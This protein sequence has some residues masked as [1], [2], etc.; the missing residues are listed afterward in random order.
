MRLYFQYFTMPSYHRILICSYVT[1]ACEAWTPFSRS[2]MEK[3]GILNRRAFVQATAT[4]VLSIAPPLVARSDDIGKAVISDVID[5]AETSATE[6]R[7]TV[8]KTIYEVASDDENE[9]IEAA[10]ET[11]DAIQKGEEEILYEIKKEEADEMNAGEDERELIAEI[12][13]QINANKDEISSKTTRELIEKLEEEEETIEEETLDLIQRVETLEA[14]SQE[15]QRPLFPEPGTAED[16]I[17]KSKMETEEFVSKLK[18]RATEKEDLITKLKAQSAKDI[19]PKTG[20]YKIMTKVEFESRAPSDFD[21]L[22]YLQEDLAKDEV[23][24]RDLDF[25]RERLESGRGLLEN[26]RESLLDKRRQVLEISKGKVDSGMEKMIPVFESSKEKLV[27][28][29]DKLAP[30]FETTKEMV[31]AG[32]ESFQSPR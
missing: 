26:S 29:K 4:L 19:D 7:N 22:K 8:D 25:F 15:A 9:T 13:E 21:F 18:E 32:L 20:K 11:I 30:V 24:Q 12:E 27:L 28:G 2:R 16:A 23:F 10:K 17:T 6:G 3:E 14:E 1:L 5:T 31:E